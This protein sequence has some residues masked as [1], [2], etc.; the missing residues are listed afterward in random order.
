MM[1]TQSSKKPTI[2]ERCND[3]VKISWSEIF[4]QNGDDIYEL[5]LYDE[6]A[7]WRLIYWYCECKM[8]NLH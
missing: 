6:L 1:T 2:L 3:S 4:P 7:G 8:P 5:E